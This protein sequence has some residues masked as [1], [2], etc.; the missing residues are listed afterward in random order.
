M[1]VYCPPV[2][3]H[4]LLMSLF[5]RLR[6]TGLGAKDQNHLFFCENVQNGA[7][8]QHCVSGKGVMVFCTNASEPYSIILL[9]PLVISQ[10]K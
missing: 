10:M 4:R 1:G 7:V 9:I 3:L 8:H 2:V 6:P 5:L